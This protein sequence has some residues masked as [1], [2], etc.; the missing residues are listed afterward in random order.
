MNYEKELR[1]KISSLSDNVKLMK[2]SD[3][4]I[5]KWMCVS[6]EYDKT[7]RRY[8]VYIE[9]PTSLLSFTEKRFMK[10][11]TDTLDG[12]DKYRMLFSVYDQLFRQFK[13]LDFVI[14]SVHILD[15]GTIRTWYSTDN[16][17]VDD[18]HLIINFDLINSNL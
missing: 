11:Y 9:V 16:G 3:R 8:F 15:D 17:T 1:N 5:R 12:D 4:V 7:E 13:H 14:G 18:Q 10:Y 6:V 2:V